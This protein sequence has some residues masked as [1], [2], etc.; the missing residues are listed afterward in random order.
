MRFVV[1]TTDVSETNPKVKP[2]VSGPYS[3]REM[4]KEIIESDKMGF[5][6]DSDWK[7]T[8][9]TIHPITTSV[10]QIL[11]NVKNRQKEKPDNDEG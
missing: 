6:G 5:I 3:F 9:Y 8:V 4:V 2:Y 11:L 7:V 10:E 1:E